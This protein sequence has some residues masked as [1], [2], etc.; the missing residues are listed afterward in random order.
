MP[1]L[2]PQ[3]WASCLGILFIQNLVALKPVRTPSA[4][5]EPQ[6]A[7]SSLW[8]RPISTPRPPNLP[9]LKAA[10]WQ[11]LQPVRGLILRTRLYLPAVCPPALHSSSP[12]LAPWIPPAHSHQV[13]LTSSY[14]N[15]K[16]ICFLSPHPLPSAQ[17]AGGG[18]PW[19]GMP[20]PLGLYFPLV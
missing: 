18:R 17:P 1:T 11:A 15:L 5:F 16:A 19:R 7:F 12:K 10:Q 2:W 8:Y 13:P 20:P 9:H 14:I 3:A 6:L 4:P